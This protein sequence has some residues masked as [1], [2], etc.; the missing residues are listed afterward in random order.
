M[1]S[2]GEFSRATQLT[3][4]ALRLYHQEGLL[5]PD[6]IDSVS[7]YRYYNIEA[8]ETAFRI[9]LLRDMDFSLEEIKKIISECRDENQLIR[10]MERKLKQINT[11][12][13]YYKHIKSSLLDFIKDTNRQK[14]TEVEF[15][16]KEEFIPDI[17]ACTI[18]KRSKYS[19]I[20]AMLCMLLGM[21]EGIQKAARLLF[22]TMMNIKKKA[23]TLRLV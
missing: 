7:G 22:T 5:I 10:H 23:L 3:I 14:N 8:I 18:R 4:K 13:S 9:K 20:G 17:T 16:V 19:E 21:P 2:I 6:K 1:L 11:D 12:I 15:N